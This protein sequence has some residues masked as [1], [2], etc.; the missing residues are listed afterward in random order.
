MFVVEDNAQAIGAEYKF[1]DGRKQ[2]L[3]TIGHIGTTSF[4]PSKNLGC[5]GDGGAIFTNDESLAAKIRMICNHGS[6]VRYY[7]D[8][9]GVNSRLD[10]IQAAV[11]DVKL[12]YLDAYNEARQKA[13]NYYSTQ[14]KAIEGITTPVTGDFTSHIYHQYTLVVEE[15]RDEIVKALGEKKI[16]HGVYYP[17][18]LHL[19]K[20]YR[21]DGYKQGDFPVSEAMSKK[22]I[23]LPMHTELTAEIQDYI[24]NGMLEAYKAQLV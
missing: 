4:F 12:K 23:S 17:V 11:L 10:A 20:A 13:A 21:G 15:G 24:I 6:S 16:A 14:L 9:I 19:Q 2:K 1:S 22:V 18:P 5:Y 8:E 7:H 3:G